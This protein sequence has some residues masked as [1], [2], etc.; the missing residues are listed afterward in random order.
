VV[1]LVVLTVAVPTASA[2][3]K[4]RGPV[5]VSKVANL[6]I[7][8]GSTVHGVASSTIRLGKRFKGRLIR[9]VD[10]TLQTTGT[11]DKTFNTSGGP[12]TG[13]FEGADVGAILRAPNGGHVTL[14]DPGDLFPP[15]LS[16]MPLALG[17]L[18]NVGPVTL[19]DEAEIDLPGEAVGLNANDPT[20]LE[21]PYVGRARPP[22][23][24]LRLL[25]GGPARGAWTLTM[26][27]GDATG[28]S[29]LASWRLRIVTGPAPELRGGKR[30]GIT[31]PVD[32]PIPNA[33]GDPP[34]ATPGVIDSSIEVG[35]IG[36]G[37]KVRDVNLTLQTLGAGGVE[38]ARELDVRLIAP[39]GAQ[40]RLF[41]L[42]D[43]PFGMSNPSIGP[44][45]LD[46]EAR[47][48]LGLGSPRNP[49]FLYMPWAGTATP[50]AELPGS[51]LAGVDGGPARG[52]W[53][54]RIIDQFPEG[55]SR[56]V[57]WRLDLVA[58]RPVKTK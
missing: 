52:T 25:E 43:G 44:L 15:V 12:L 22:V 36:R 24:P 14:F 47:L 9:D 39:S 37:R 57:F 33:V 55:R 35:R 26:R 40:A 54:L 46:D 28:T 11:G 2:K 31:K 13:P 20:V 51:A 10:V 30:I 18:P 41:F 56:L 42:L 21:P 8:D 6:A 16:T 23:K 19:D 49:H 58:G 45:T 48:N 29:N 5:N 27:D 53:T 38:P 50:L 4:N 7:P 32:A 17:A 34:T 1:L 3:K